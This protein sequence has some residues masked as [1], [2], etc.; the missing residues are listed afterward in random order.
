MSESDIED[1]QFSSGGD[2]HNW[3]VNYFSQVFIYSNRLFSNSKKKVCCGN[4]R[5]HVCTHDKQKKNEL[6][7]L[8]TLY[9]NEILG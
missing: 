5:I 8:Q 2:Q 6:H 4:Q 3:K 1:Y 7:G 9:F